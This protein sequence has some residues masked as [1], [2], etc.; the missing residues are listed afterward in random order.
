MTSEQEAAGRP[1]EE[2]AVSGPCVCHEVLDHLGKVF[3]VSPAV[4]QHLMN[5]RVEFLKAVRA[6]ID[7]RIERLSAA[8]QR[9]SHITVE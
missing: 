8:A 9:G 4:K 7:Q 3:E 2:H 6:V 1:A 5:S